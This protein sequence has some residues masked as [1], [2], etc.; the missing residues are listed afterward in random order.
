VASRRV[1]VNLA[2]RAFGIDLPS[3]EA[4][5]NSAETQSILSDYFPELKLTFGSKSQRGG[6][7]GRQTVSVTPEISLRQR[8]AAAAGSAA[9]ISTSV[10]QPAPAPTAAKRVP[11]TR[12][13]VSDVY[14]GGEDY[15][16]NIE[17]GVTP[18][19]IKDWAQS[20]PQLFREQ[21]VKGNQEGLYE[22]IM[23]GNVRVESAL[24]APQTAPTKTSAPT[25]RAPI[26]LA[27]GQSADYF[28]GKDLEAAR[29]QGYSTR[30]IFD[31]I[32]AQGANKILRDQNLPGGG[33][34]YDQLKNELN[35]PSAPSPSPSPAPSPSPSPSASPSRKPISLEYGQSPD[36][37][38]GKDLEVAKEQGYSSAEILD[39]INRSGTNKILR[40][41]NVP[42]GGGLY[43]Q[44]M[45][46]AGRS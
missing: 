15:W 18:Q 24:T 16:R 17:Q 25:G 7:L 21:N 31:F 4:E 43:D 20:N 40:D 13:G 42:G 29:A 37:F 33:G 19:E 11:S 10:Q 34:L 5:D 2:G 39:F 45:R 38:G 27:A 23:R 35:P 8:E 3:F 14:F 12:F 22:Q 44:L 41:Q 46:E 1:S 9:P 26:S 6:R 28:G 30:E 32:N 36:Y